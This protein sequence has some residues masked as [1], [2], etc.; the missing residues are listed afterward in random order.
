MGYSK[1]SKAILRVKD[2]LDEMV[3][4]NERLEWELEDNVGIAFK[5]RQAMAQASTR[6]NQGDETYAEYARLKSK[7]LIR[8]MFG[9]VI[10]EPRDVTDVVKAQQTANHMRLSGLGTS[11]EIV[12]A[13]IQ[14]KAD[15]MYFPDAYTNQA[16][17]VYPWA[18]KNGYYIVVGEGM[19]LTKNDPGELAWKP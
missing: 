9:K 3:E 2:Y 19:T 15:E 18:Q 16:S 4:K 13:A 8:T 10:A 11:L 14:H 7:Y 17:E 12:G 5:I 1:S 6:V